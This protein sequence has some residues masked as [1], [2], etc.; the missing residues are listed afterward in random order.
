M[1]GLRRAGVLV[2]AFAFLLLGCA[3]LILPLIPGIPLLVVALVLL[4]TEFVWAH[5]MLNRIRVRFPFTAP[6]LDRISQP[7]D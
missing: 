6:L 1:R 7:R 3:G 5:R 2:A 4:A